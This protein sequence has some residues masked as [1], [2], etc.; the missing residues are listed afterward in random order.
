MALSGKKHVTQTTTSPQYDGLISGYW[1]KGMR[2]QI[3]NTPPPGGSVTGGNAGNISWQALKE[4]KAVKENGKPLYVQGHLLNN[5]LGGP[6]TNNQNLTPLTNKSNGDFERDAEKFIK[7]RLSIQAGATTGLD[8]GLLF[9]YTVIPVYNRI[10]N[11]GLINNI[12]AVPAGPVS[13]PGSPPVQL[14]ANDK[15][16]LINVVTHERFVPTQLRYD[17]IVKNPI[18]NKELEQ[19]SV[20]YHV[21]ENDISQSTYIISSGIF[22]F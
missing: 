7:S 9:I 2:V 21:L 4:R 14:T 8:T 10:V 3:I 13:I 1:G 20:R 16:V 12:N 18:T 17:I 11:T 5:N 6:G 15:T 22:T 19:F